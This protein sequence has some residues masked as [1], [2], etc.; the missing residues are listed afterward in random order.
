[1]KNAEVESA[2]GLGDDGEEAVVGQGDENPS[3]HAESRR[4]R[5]DPIADVVSL[6]KNWMLR[7]IQR[8]GF[9]GILLLAAYPNTAFDLCGITCGHFLMPFWEF[10]GAT[11]LGKGL[12]KVAGQ[13]AFFVALF[14]QQSR[15]QVFAWLEEALPSEVPLI[16]VGDLTPAQWLHRSVNTRIRAFQESVAARKAVPGARAA[17][18]SVWGKACR[19]P[20][21]LRDPGALL[22]GS[23]AR[24]RL[25][26]PWGLLTTLMVAS[27][28]R[29]VV[30]QFAQGYAADKDREM[31]HA[32]VRV[33]LASEKEEE[34]EE[35][36]WR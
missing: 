18:A 13:T 26:S 6:M 15:E 21:V 34:E 17:A 14:Q 27:F 10:F 8:H 9:W 1:M 11:L 7:F 35:K 19:I 24:L 32:R 25:P 22:R 12:I 31:L 5:G 4:R 20:G 23:L 2:L 29:S 3:V 28:V 36:A 33:L 16:S 30:E